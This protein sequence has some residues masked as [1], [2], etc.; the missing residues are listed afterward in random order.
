MSFAKAHD[1]LKLTDFARAQHR[2]VTL[3]DIRAEFGVS[4]RTA[5][6][7]T[8]ALEEIFPFAVTISEDLDR[9]RR[10]KLAEVPLAGLRLGGD[11]ELA[12]LEMATARLRG[13]GDLR[14]A[15]AL[16]AL[17]HRLLA[18][19][20]PKDA[21]RA[22]ADAEALLE[23]HGMAA[24]PGPVATPDPALSDLVA[25]ALRAPFV[26]ELTYRGERRRV[27]P[28]GILIG[29]RRYLV[30]RQPERDTAFR[31]FRLDLI[32]DAAVTGD[33]FARD[34]EFNLK[35]HAARAFGSYQAE[36]EYDEVIWR[37]TPDAAPRAR[38][39]RFHPDQTT[40]DLPDGR[41][42]VRF[43]ASGWL[44]MAWHLYQWGAAV[45]VVAPAA[46][47]ELVDD[48]RRADFASLP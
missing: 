47:R 29:A 39:W 31:H 24:R 3:E 15:R 42:E 5:Q 8:D 43:H 22:E 32:E 12:A 1:I 28:Y 46:L 11:A 44:E 48:H 23:A 35:T 16:S 14:E 26:M 13:D 9:R 36:V 25:E 21:R 34:P 37:F 19:L 4:H 30:A 2:G 6:R 40:T 38:E 27:E 45:E 10:W 17:K 33:W 20:P 41:L 7:M 18:A